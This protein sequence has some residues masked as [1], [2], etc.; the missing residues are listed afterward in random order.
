MVGSSELEPDLTL[1][2]GCALTAELRALS[3]NIKS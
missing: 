3:I 1:K 2:T